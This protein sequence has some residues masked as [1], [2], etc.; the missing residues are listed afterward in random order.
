MN[1]TNKPKWILLSLIL[2]F[3]Q[4]VMA[5]ESGITP[6]SD[7]AEMKNLVSVNAWLEGA[8]KNAKATQSTKH[9]NTAS[10]GET[11]DQKAALDQKEAVYAVSEQI[12]MVVEVS[13]PR[14]LTGGTRIGNIEI[15]NVIVKQRNP[16]ATNYTQRRDGQTWS[17]QRWEIT[18]YPQVSGQF[19]IPPTSVTAQVSAPNGQNVQANLTTPPLA[20]K[21]SLPSGLLSG[22]QGWVAASALTATEQWQVSR[23]Q[24]ELKVGDSITRSVT[25]TG[26]D[27]LSVLL[28]PLLAATE[29]HEPSD[30][31]H[32]YPQPNALADSQSRGNYQSS[33]TEE[34]VYVLQKGGDLY[35][36]NLKLQWWNTKTQ[37]LETLTLEGRHFTVK[38]TVGSWLSLYGPV[39][40]TVLALLVTSYILMRMLVR[41][42][43]TRPTPQWLVFSRALKTKSWATARVLVYRKLRGQTQ[44]LELH[45]YQASSSWQSLSQRLQQ[46]KLSRAGFI[47]VWLKIKKVTIK[48]C[49]LPKALPALETINTKNEL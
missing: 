34:V 43:R 46:A 17:I 2:L 20:F 23:D 39:L 38:H 24:G 8:D 33:R 32:R 14:W 26:T 15:P 42:Y 47:R 11:S 45:Q 18:L 29:N 35:F 37:Q 12:I 44:Q 27:T 25:L 28:P 40:F 30:S 16:L 3:L 10:D 49:S 7:Q 21:A 13:T 9:S 5:A 22:G 4:P 6:K 41:Y 36:P 48:G 1:P 31:Y 19:H